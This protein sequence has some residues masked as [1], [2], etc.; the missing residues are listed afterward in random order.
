M[1]PHRGSRG[2]TFRV[3]SEPLTGS[4]HAWRKP[5]VPMVDVGSG[6]QGYRINSIFGKNLDLSVAF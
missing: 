5:F 4:S 6:A 2:A 1:F 3:S